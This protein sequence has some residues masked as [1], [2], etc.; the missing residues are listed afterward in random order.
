MITEEI[1]WIEGPIVF[2]PNRAPITSDQHIIH[3]STPQLSR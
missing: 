2:Y 1:C 3:H